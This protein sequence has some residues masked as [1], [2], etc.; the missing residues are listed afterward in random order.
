MLS[1]LVTE[2][3]ADSKLIDEVKSLSPMELKDSA[4]G[5][6]IPVVGAACPESNALYYFKC[7]GKLLDSCCFRLQDWVIVLLL[8][9][10]VLTVLA[11]VFNIIRCI[12]CMG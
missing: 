6:P 2:T 10:A 5:C 11:I 4:L 9:M 8:V 12:F 3:N 1:I 7:C